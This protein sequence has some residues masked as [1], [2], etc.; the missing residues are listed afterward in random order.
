[1]AKDPAFLFYPKD[2]I[3]GTGEMMPDE[4][5]I[6]IDLLCYQHQRGS[7]PIDE[8]RLAKMVGLSLDE[9]LKSWDIIKGKFNRMDDRLV[10]QRLAQEVT[11]RKSK[12]QKNRV[13]G[14]FASLLRTGNYDKKTYKYIREGFNVADYTDTDTERITKRLTEWIGERLKSIASA[15]EDASA[16]KDVFI[17]PNIEQVKEYFLEKGYKES[18]AKKAH[19]YYTASNWKDSK[20]NQVKN[21]KQKMIGVWFK[22]EHEMTEIDK[23]PK[24]VYELYPNKDE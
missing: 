12:S 16:S 17:P 4:K 2:W 14:I 13:I 8:K 18:V 6:Y 7:L 3:E 19:D 22:P 15:S 21:W 11:E 10:N 1:M 24:R 23:Q 5:G 20:G 9:F